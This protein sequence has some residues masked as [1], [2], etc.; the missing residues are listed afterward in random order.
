[1]LLLTGIEFNSA[2]DLPSSAD[3]NSYL[4]SKFSLANY[5]MSDFFMKTLLAID[6]EMV[7]PIVPRGK[8]ENDRNT[9]VKDSM[10]EGGVLL[11]AQ[12]WFNI[13]L[14]QKN[15]ESLIRQ[16]FQVIS[17][18]ISWIDIKL[19]VNTTFVNSMFAYLRHPSLRDDVAKC[20]GSIIRKGMLPNEKLSLIEFLDVTN[21]LSQLDISGDSFVEEVAKL[22]NIIGIELKS[23]WLESNDSELQLKDKSYNFIEQLMPMSLNFLS[24]K[25]NS[26]SSSVFGVIGEVL[27]LFKKQNKSGVQLSQEKIQFLGQLLQ[28]VVVKL[29]YDEDYELS[30]NIRAT[31]DFTDQSRDE[32]DE[33]SMFA[34]IRH[35]LRQF[36]DAIYF[37]V[38]KE[39]EEYIT[40][41]IRQIFNNIQKVGLLSSS[42]EANSQGGSTKVKW[43][44]AELAVHLTHIFIE[45]SSS[46]GVLIFSKDQLNSINQTKSGLTKNLSNN[47]DVSNSKKSSELTDFGNLCLHLITSGVSNCVNPLV[48]LM[49]YETCVRLIQLFE[50]R[51]E[52]IPMVLAPFLDNRGIH[53]HHLYTRTRIWYFLYRFIRLSR[54]EE[55]AP[56]TSE[57]IKSITPLLAIQVQVSISTIQGGIKS[58]NGYGLLDSQLY[59]FEACGILLSYPDLPENE[60]VTSLNKVLDPLFLGVQ[61]LMGQSFEFFNT[62][63]IALLQIHHCLTAIGSV[64]QGFPDAKINSNPSILTEKFDTKVSP[65]L[66]EYLKK[67]ANISSVALEALN[68]Y[69]IIRE[70]VRFVFTRL[71]SALGQETLEY[72]PRLINGLVSTSE[73]DELSDFLT[74]LGLIMYRFKPF[75]SQIVSDLL[76][77][78]IDKVYSVLNSTISGTDDAIMSNN[79]KKAYLTWIT[80]IF[81]ADLDC[82]FLSDGNAPHLVTVLKT[83]LMLA[84]DNS[85]PAIQ[86]LSFSIFHKTIIGWLIDTHGYYGLGNISLVSGYNAPSSASN[87]SNQTFPFTT[88]KDPSAVDK[89][90]KSDKK[91]LRQLSAECIRLDYDSQVV[92][93]TRSVFRNFIQQEVLPICFQI[94]SSAE[95]DMF[96]A[97]SF[98]TVNEIC[99]VLRGF[100]LSGQKNSINILSNKLKAGPI[101]YVPNNFDIPANFEKQVVSENKIL[102]FLLYEFLP[103]IGCTQDSSTNFVQGLAM[104][105][106]RR[107]KSFFQ[108]FISQAKAR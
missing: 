94:P 54:A 33:D 49:F 40:G 34:N 11:L 35:T 68:S 107:F 52:A 30:D 18:Y 6:E 43:I 98:Q 77:T 27:L 84:V 71:I 3:P 81:N 13:L 66:S 63:P 36:L 87:N 79:L 83:V 91:T 73:L 22:I 96:D 32:D 64:F 46:R 28:V 41:V 53:H 65:I 4:D 7:N 72:L 105:D 92:S 37:L 8:N 31:P 16:A 95:F 58:L 102:S 1:M 61:Q 106:S 101:V 104:L 108:T 55:I 48:S 15:P 50:Y 14:Y 82:I 90:L 88:G 57:I 89:T 76:L 45:Q 21:V 100:A 9:F 23:I 74:F 44:Q 29:Q 20:L 80:S 12:W 25:E 24:N 70:G 60:R 5:N 17:V 93:Q 97:Q 86:R 85:S 75:I 39:Y 56:Y 67:A 38:P 10:R 47:K 51:T 62:Q 59:L 19:I 103:S 78:V 2:L 42:E 99:G 69:T 26:I